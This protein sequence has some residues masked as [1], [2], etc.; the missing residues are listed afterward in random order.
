MKAHSGIGRRYSIETL[1][2]TVLLSSITF[3]TDQTANLYRAKCSPCHGKN[4]EGKPAMKVPSLVSNEAKKISDQE[5]REL[6]VTRANGEV[7]R[8]P[9]HKFLKKRLTEDQIKQ[10]IT[11]I[12]KMQE[13]HH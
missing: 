12:R 4:G 8:N 7:D 2:F 9:S 13:S 6:I 10:I 3:A 5:I 1:V 11:D